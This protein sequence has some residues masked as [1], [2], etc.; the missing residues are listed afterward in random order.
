MAKNLS[1]SGSGH[2]SGMIDGSSLK[3]YVERV[4]RLAEERKV[5]NE[6][7]KEVCE[8]AKEA[9]FPSKQIRQLAREQ[10]MDPEVL[11]DHLAQMES[12]RHAIGQLQGTPLGKSAEKD[13]AR[14]RRRRDPDDPQID[15]ED[16]L[17]SA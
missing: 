11:E 10:M 6:D 15:I 3:G 5:L 14:T 17:G 9:G 8:E 1:S 12:L 2:N 7:I 13:A 16:T 4:V